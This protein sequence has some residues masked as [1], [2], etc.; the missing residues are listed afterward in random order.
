MIICGM[1]FIGWPIA[2]V[3]GQSGVV[4]TDEAASAEPRSADV[5]QARVEV[6]ASHP[7]KQFRASIG[8][9]DLVLTEEESEGELRFKVEEGEAVLELS[10]Q[11]EEAVSRA[12]VEF[13]L[14]PEGLPEKKVV[15]WAENEEENEEVVVISWDEHYFERGEE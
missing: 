13:L 3:T 1:A 12:A 10:I 4:Q 11:W 5:Q 9:D 2:W 6:K 8:E 7:F 14:M 15:F